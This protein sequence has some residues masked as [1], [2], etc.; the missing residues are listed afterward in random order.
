MAKKKNVIGK[1]TRKHAKGARKWA[2]ST[3]DISDLE[4]VYRSQVKSNP[5]KA[6][7]R[8]YRILDRLHS[9]TSKKRRKK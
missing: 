8:D 2:R 5:K 9:V 7:Y 3:P 6:T 4:L 1:I